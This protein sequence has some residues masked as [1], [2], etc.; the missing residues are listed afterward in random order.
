MKKV[1]LLCGGNSTEHNVSLLSAK[2][3]LENIDTD[4]FE[5]TPVII[6]FDNI[7]YEYLDEYQYL[8]NWQT[9]NVRIIDNIVEYLYSFDV[10]FPIIHGYGGED[11][12][13]QGMLD[14]FDIKYVGCKTLSSA[15]CMDKDFSKM[16]FSYLEIPQV[17]FITLTNSDFKLNDIV[18]N[19]GFP[20]IVKP[21]NGGSS[22]GIS[23]VTSK[24]GLKKAINDAF[25][26]DEKVVIE[27]FINARELECAVL[28]EE[29]YY[30]SE[31]GEIKSANEFYD[32]EA[33]Y[34]NNESY[35]VIP[36]ELEESV[37]DKIK[38]YAEIAFKGINCRGLARIDFFYDEE[39]NE[40]YL[41]E[42]NTL[43]GFTSISMY[44]KLFIN[45]G[46]SYKD[47][48]TKLINNS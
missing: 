11:G 21:A 7:W 45:E 23:K 14:L 29:D 25:K 48:I 33:K 20:M 36:A 12:K 13:L 3:I 31:V 22:I 32:Y 26:Y 18:K 46:I 17:P 30:I 24:R 19:I 2:S 6:D 5:V 37:S 16:I 4:I 40:I 43:P 38:E 34:I 28:E 8:D 15:A 10:I 47:L 44:P 35:T 41:N 27:K 42:I 39:N 1:L 9:K